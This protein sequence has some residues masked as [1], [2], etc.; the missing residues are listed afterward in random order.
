MVI[1]KSLL[2]IVL[3]QLRCVPTSTPQCQYPSKKQILLRQQLI[4][5]WMAVT[6]IM[7]NS[8]RI[9]HT[10]CGRFK[11]HLAQ[12]EGEF[13]V[14]KLIQLFQM[15]YSLCDKLNL[16]ITQTVKCIWKFTLPLWNTFFSSKSSTGGVWILNGVARYTW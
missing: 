9:H 6:D 13:Q 8:I 2:T 5:L 15:K 14:D 11:K 12:G 1:I 16:E 4:N 7:G 10:P 3:K